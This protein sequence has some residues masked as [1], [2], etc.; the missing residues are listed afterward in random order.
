MVQMVKNLP[1]V[2]ET[3]I[4]FQGW[5]DALET[6][7][8]AHSS[9][10]AWRIPWPEESGGLQSMGSQKSQTRLRN[11]HL[12]LLLMQTWVEQK[13]QLG[14][15]KGLSRFLR[16]PSYSDIK[17]RKTQRINRDR[18]VCL[19]RLQVSVFDTQRTLG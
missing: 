9:I 16:K 7:M 19:Q 11:E 6:G 1:A 8:A 5:K 10:L 15:T 4:Q 14:L 18:E 3:W 17:S 2:Q 13:V 12:H